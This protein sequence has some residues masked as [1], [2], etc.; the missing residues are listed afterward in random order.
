MKIRAIAPW[1]GGKRVMAPVIVRE[2]GPHRAYWDPFCGSLAVLLAKPPSSHETVSDLH[3][4]LINLARVVQDPDLAP[5]LYDRLCRTLLSEEIF[6]RSQA[7]FMA[8]PSVECNGQPDVDLAYDYFVVSWIGRNGVSGTARSNYQ[9]AV[10]WTHHGGHGAGRFRSAVESLPA[11]HQ[12]L[13]QTAILQRDAFA[14]IPNIDDASG[15]A[16]YIDPPYFEGSRSG[17]AKYLYDFGSD[18]DHARLAEQL[19]RFTQARVVVSYYDH[20]RLTELYPDW[21]KIDHRRSKHLHVQFKRGA[22]R[23]EAPE[24][25]LVNGPSYALTDDAPLLNAA[26]A[27]G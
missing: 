16:I 11:W 27:G 24:V 14:V 23:S 26:G 7:A 3:G 19:G 25:L 22:K 18:D 10:R 9:M 13:R 5:R 1:F 15:V 12:R 21:T 8:A 20:P 4:H 6:K 2:L 17:T